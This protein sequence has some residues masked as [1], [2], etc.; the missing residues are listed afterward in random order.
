MNASKVAMAM[1]CVSPAW[2][3]IS[4][5]NDADMFDVLQETCIHP[6][7]TMTLDAELL[8]SSLRQLSPPQALTLAHYL[9]K[10]MGKYS[11]MTQAFYLICFIAA[12]IVYRGNV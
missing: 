6:I 9:L 5:V 7:V 12:C 3:S 1:H 2:L 8:M 11:G 4:P 10:L